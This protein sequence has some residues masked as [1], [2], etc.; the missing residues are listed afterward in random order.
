[1]KRRL[2]RWL[3][4]AEKIQ[5][6]RWLH[7][8]GPALQHPRLWHISR[9]GIA[10]GLAL[11]VFFG[12]LL[13]VAQIPGSAAAAVVLRA[14]LPMAV[15]STFVTNPVT[16]GPIYYA[17]YRLG[18]A[19]LGHEHVET[20][21]AEAALEEIKR[22][23]DASATLFERLKSWLTNLTTIGKPLMVGLAILATVSAI[24]VYFLVSEA[25]IL[26]TRWDRRQ[27]TRHRH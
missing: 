22:E 23:A 2:K 3:P 20:P 9:K 26:K 24:V 13:P 5:G 21:E 27:R 19:V 8:L 18:A 15:A 17:A 12:I 4:K 11:G 10:L 7:W 14:N 16:F 1:M 6:N 25:W